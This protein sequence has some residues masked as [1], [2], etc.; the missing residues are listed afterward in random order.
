MPDPS[1]KRGLKLTLFDDLA[2]VSDPATGAYYTFNTTAGTVLE[3]LAEGEPACQATLRLVQRYGLDAETAKAHVEQL[4]ESLRGE[5]LLS[6]AAPVRGR[7]VVLQELQHLYP[8]G[9]SAK[10]NRWYME[11]LAAAGY[12]VSVYCDIDSGP[13]RTMLGSLWSQD[14]LDPVPNRF[15]DAIE[16]DVNGVRLL[17]LTENDTPTVEQVARL[18]PDA[19]I[20]SEDRTFARHEVGFE[21]GVPTM[22]LT[23]RPATLPFGRHAW[24][25]SPAATDLFMGAN[26]IVAPNV[27]MAEYVRTWTGRNARVVPPPPFAQPRSEPGT[28]RGFVTLVNPSEIKGISLFLELAR[29]LPRHRFA[30]VPGWSTTDDDLRRLRDQPNVTLVRP[31][32]DIARVLDKTSVLVAPSL[33]QESPGLAV[34]EAML[35]SIPTVVSAVGSLPEVKRGVEYVL[36][37]RGIEEYTGG[38]DGQG[39]AVPVIPEQDPE[40]VETWA[41]VVDRLMTER[42]HW[43]QIAQASHTAA[44]VH[45]EAAAGSSLVGL[46]GE[47][48]GSRGAVATAA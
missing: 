43:E 38:E 32:R 25:N 47:L 48:L 14:T 4:F 7:I 24:N 37:V 34:T 20:V 6:A 19:I 41:T 2:V 17:A 31:G 11:Q 15:D 9:G 28:H 23:A 22:W 12:D 44:L 16:F 33:W 21:I 1:L 40:T 26:E 29:R 8:F 36:P 45:A 27:F 10:V 13:T 18:E 5:G 35:R 42:D 30:A 3:G 39:V 46:I